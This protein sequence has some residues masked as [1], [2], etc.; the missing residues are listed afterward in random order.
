M[1]V[2]DSP[3]SRIRE[4]NGFV[5]PDQSF[6]LSED[7]Q[8]E[9]VVLFHPVVM[10]FETLRVLDLCLLHPAEFQDRRNEADGKN[11]PI[12]QRAKR[13]SGIPLHGRV[14]SSPSC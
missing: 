11:G 13:D 7:F 9:L 1:P 3:L 10:L 14:R 6:E 2:R 12:D 4:L 8:R 5:M